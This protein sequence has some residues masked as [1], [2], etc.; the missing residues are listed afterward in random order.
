MTDEE[1]HPCSI[2]AFKQFRAKSSE[3]SEGVYIFHTHNYFNPELP[4]EVEI[5]RQFYKDLQTRFKGACPQRTDLAQ[6]A[7]FALSQWGP[8]RILTQ[9]VL[10]HC[11]GSQIRPSMGL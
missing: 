3:G 1:V 10:H 11:L 9:Q 4:S 8:Q 5:G 6:P 2:E 7:A